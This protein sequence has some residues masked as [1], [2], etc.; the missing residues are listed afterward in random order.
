MTLL[1]T[2]AV[3]LMLLWL[4]QRQEPLEFMPKSGSRQEK[5]L[6]EICYRRKIV[7]YTQRDGPSLESKSYAIEFCIEPQPI[8]KA[9]GIVIIVLINV[10]LKVMIRWLIS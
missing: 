5:I 1:F 8:G 9:L 10:M 3:A 2:L 6:F 7:K 4:W